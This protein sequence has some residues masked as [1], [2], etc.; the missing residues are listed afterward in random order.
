[1]CVCV[2][3]GV[4]P[5]AVKC[6]RHTVAAAA[7]QRSKVAWEG[8]GGGTNKSLLLPRREGGEWGFQGLTATT[9]LWRGVFSAVSAGPKP[10]AA[11]APGM[12]KR[13]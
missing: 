1:M 2:A 3:G 13:M 4:T 6:R 5:T 8:G 9:V 11:S 12:S 10:A 7:L